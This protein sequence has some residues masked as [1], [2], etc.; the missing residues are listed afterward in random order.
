MSAMWRL[1]GGT[2]SPQWKQ[3]GALDVISAV[4]VQQKT[5]VPAVAAA[6]LTSVKFGQAPDLQADCQGRVIVACVRQTAMLRSS[7]PAA[8]PLRPAR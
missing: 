3:A 5:S 1:P 6:R 4:A 2:G 8:E 7:I